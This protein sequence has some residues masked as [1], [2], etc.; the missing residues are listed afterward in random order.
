MIELRYF[1]EKIW[2]PIGEEE[3]L[4]RSSRSIVGGHFHT[5]KVNRDVALAKLKKGRVTTFY[6]EMRWRE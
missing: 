6:G 5:R 2:Y 1:G 4:L 3:F